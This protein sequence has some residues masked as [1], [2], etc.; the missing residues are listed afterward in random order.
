MNIILASSSPRRK[1]LLKEIFK[2][3]TVESKEVDET[4]RPNVSLE[5]NIQEVALK[6]ANAIKYIDT[7]VIGADTI[8]VDNDEVLLKPVDYDDAFR[9]LSNLSEKRHRVITG[10]AIVMNNVT[11][12]FFDET[13]VSFNK[14][15]DQMINHY[16]K[17]CQPF[18]KAGSYGLQELDSTWIK[19]VEGSRNNVIGLPTEKLKAKIDEFLL[20]IS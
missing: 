8:V 10:V 16:I 17:K 3:F 1:E 15:T 20:K 7:L 4:F 9:M 11:L 2:D 18:D 14:L 19:K 5:M 12:T 13:F 6:K